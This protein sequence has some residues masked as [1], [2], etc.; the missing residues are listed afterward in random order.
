MMDM[1]YREQF[2]DALNV[3]VNDQARAGLDIVTT[4]DYYCD[5]DFFGRSWVNYPLERIAGLAGDVTPPAS[6]WDL[7]EANPPGTLLHE[8]YTN[9]KGPHVVAPIESKRDNLEYARIWRIAQASSKKPVKFGSVSAQTLAMLAEPKIER[10]LSDNRRQLL[11]DFSVA[12]NSELRTLAEA[13]CEVIQIEEPNFHFLDY[14]YSSDDLDFMIEAFNREIEGL[15]NVEVW[16]HTCFGNPNMQRVF[17]ATHYRD[18]AVEIYLERLKGDVL[19]VE[20]KE[21]D[22]RDLEAFA[23]YRGNMKKKLAIG[24]V[25]HRNLQVEKPSEVASDVRHALNHVQLENIVL[26]SDCG[27]GRQGC[28]RSIAFYKAAAISQGA[29]IIRREHGL[30]ESEIPTAD[31]KLQ[32]EVLNISD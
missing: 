27:F 29:N 6:R 12:M 16:I 2:S 25:S 11:W 19:T 24:V 13:G 8:I 26:S 30:P 22:G 5:E 14:P 18:E 9:W 1:K 28:S 4:G 31:P 21:R 10:Y 17:D 23:R 32:I 7:K 20:M 3:V 15:E